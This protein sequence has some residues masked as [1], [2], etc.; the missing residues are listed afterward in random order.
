MT[1]RK[2]LSTGIGIILILLLA[3]GIVSYFQIGQID[4]NLTEI[5]Q[6]K[7]LGKRIAF[8]YQ[9]YKT[10]DNTLTEKKVSQ[11]SLFATNTEN[12]EQIDNIINDKI[13]AGINLEGPDGHEKMLQTSK[14]EADI[15]EVA[16]SL[17]IY[18]QTPENKYKKRIFDYAGMFEQDV[19]MFKNL[20]L[21]KEEKDSTT[22]LET[23]F[24]QTMSLTKDILVIDDYL[25]KNTSKHRDM[26]ASIDELLGEEFEVFTHTDLYRAK[27]A[28]RKIVGTAVIVTLILVLTGLLDV[29]VFSASITKSIT[30]PITKLKDAMTEIGRGDF[31]TKIEIESNDEIGQLADAFNQ[32]AEQRKQARQAL[33]KAHDDLEVRVE[34][35]TA[36]L[37]RANE[38][39]ESE[40]A[41]RE[42]AEEE[43]EKSNKD[44]ELAIRELSR[45]NK[46]LQEFA[47]IAAHDLKTPLR[48]IGTLADW[49]STDYADKF[50]EQ[51]KEQV[52]MLVSRAKR[53]SALIDN[54]MQYS[55]LGHNDQ[56]KQQVDLNTVLSEVIVSIAPPENIEITIEN[57]LPTL[58]CTKKHIVQVFQNLLGNAVKYMD[59][60]KGKIQVG[61]IPED[62]F[63]KF[64]VADNGPGINQKYSEKI[65]R[66][67]QTLS[68]RDKTENTGIGL[69][70]AK[71]IIELNAGNIW[72]ESELGRGST[73]FFT[74]PKSSVC[75]PVSFESAAKNKE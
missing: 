70:I 75:Q 62:G 3:L 49:L 33:Q 50:D 55:R 69:S 11:K 28:S 72:V 59:K 56:E 36:E 57:E 64:S 47:Y 8:L 5:I 40:I 35:R 51:G 42:M 9:Q 60:P 65:F 63:W 14:M 13:H 67:F 29:F 38:V 19:E 73:F 71:K 46:E 22:K 27:E 74:L 68:P 16:A 20:R 26:R 45:S 15:A 53:M 10:L 37:I 25:Q 4:E 18:L 48:G 34:K 52:R 61:C 21:T 6:G 17:R 24:N 1:I 7:E 58:M 41:E 30:K 23:V 54:I 66:I 44:L 2:K 39:L 12:F 32:M 43:L 31:D